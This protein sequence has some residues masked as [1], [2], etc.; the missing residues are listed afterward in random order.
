MK[1]IHMA[2]RE[3]YCTTG[4]CKLLETKSWREP[5]PR[6][7]NEPGLRKQ[8]CLSVRGRIRVEAYSR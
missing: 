5:D 1:S 3:S 8:R 4:V 6:K 7:M 2:Q